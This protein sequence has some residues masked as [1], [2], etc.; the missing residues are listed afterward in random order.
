MSRQAEQVTFMLLETHLYHVIYLNTCRNSLFLCN[1]PDYFSILSSTLLLQEP[2]RLQQKFSESFNNTASPISGAGLASYA[3][4]TSYTYDMTGP[5][6]PSAPPAYYSYPG[7]D[8]LGGAGTPGSSADWFPT[9]AGLVPEQFAVAEQSYLSATSPSSSYDSWQGLPQADPL[10]YPSMPALHYLPAPE[11][12]EALNAFENYPVVPP[13]PPVAHKSAVKRKLEELKTEVEDCQPSSSGGE[14]GA[15][16]AARKRSRDK[17]GEMVQ[18]QED[19]FT[20]IKADKERNDVDRRWANNQRERVRIKDINEALKELGRICSAH[21]KSDKPMTKLGIL[22]N[23]VD[24]IVSL[25]QQVRDRKLN[26]AVACL[27]RQ[28]QGGER[29]SPSDLQSPSL[30]P[31]LT[32]GSATSPND[33][34][35]QLLAPAPSLGAPSPS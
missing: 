8:A 12:D 15:K 6:F 26:P 34:P 32:P 18:G 24:V 11:L 35:G 17:G 27:Q 10:P 2:M 4:T 9:I 30:H 3:A 21:Q 22:N 7:L 1:T 33:Y 28:V 20:D 25:E 23:A 31:T 13:A 19:A 29:V 5:S 14:E 16:V